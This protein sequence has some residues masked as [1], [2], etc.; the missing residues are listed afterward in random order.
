MPRLGSAVRPT[1]SKR[2]ARI[3]CIHMA[4]SSIVTHPPGT[5]AAVATQNWSSTESERPA[6]RQEDR[7]RPG[8]PA[9]SLTEECHTA[10]HLTREPLATGMATSYCSVRRTVAGWRLPRDPLAAP[11]SAYRLGGI[12]RTL[13]GPCEDGWQANGGCAQGGTPSCEPDGPIQWGKQKSRP[14]GLEP[15]TCGLG[16]RIER[17]LSSD[18]D[19]ACESAQTNSA[20]CSAFLDALPTDLVL[21]VQAWKDLPEA[22]K[23]GIL[24]MVKASKPQ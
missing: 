5:R 9:G 12:R 7:Q 13:G 18:C 3:A 4:V 11:T 8:L 14:T 24:A 19:A 21:V 23:T 1:V 16:N 15:V 6:I 10:A 22:L 2:V 17:S 20:V